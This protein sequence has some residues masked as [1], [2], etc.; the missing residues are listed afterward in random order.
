VT[1]RQKPTVPPAPGAGEPPPAR[2]RYRAAMAEPGGT[3][4][5]NRV[6]GPNRSLA[7]RCVVPVTYRIATAFARVAV[8]VY[9]PRLRVTG[10][11][12]LPG[13][14]GAIIV[15]NHIDLAD[16]CVLAGVLPRRVVFLAMRKL[17]GW[18]LVGLLPRM[19][20]ALPVDDSGGPTLDLMRGSLDAL[21]EGLAVVIFPE[22]ER[23]RGALLRGMAGAALL[24]YRSGTP[25]VPVAITGTESVRWPWVLLRPL[26]GPR[27]TVTFGEP[28]ALPRPERMTAASA[29]EG[30]DAVMRRIAALLPEAYRGVYA[31]AFPAG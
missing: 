19:L 30:I 3:P 8:R 31:D 26:L 25:I 10:M 29:Q 15:S 7:A 16:P 9:F 4:A 17:F 14:G 13:I 1:A 27:V 22:G 5:P 21:R 11:E 18:P 12:R 23:D 2:V 6:R 20:G 28:F 24:A